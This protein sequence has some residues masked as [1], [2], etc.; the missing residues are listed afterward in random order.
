MVQLFMPA[1]YST[2]Q[3]WRQQRK[4]F[5]RLF[6]VFTQENSGVSNLDFLF[7]ESWLETTEHQSLKNT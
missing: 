3:S 6:N 4:N 7:Q 1:V 5:I 2:A